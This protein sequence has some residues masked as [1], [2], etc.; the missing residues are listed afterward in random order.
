[1]LGT[2]VWLDGQTVEITGF[3]D[4]EDDVIVNTPPLSYTPLSS[5]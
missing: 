4:T 1:M 5:Q 2:T 3:I